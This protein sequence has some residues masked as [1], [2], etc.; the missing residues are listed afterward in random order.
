M[1]RGPSVTHAPKSLRHRYAREVMRLARVDDPRIEAVFAGTPREDFLPP[2]PWTILDAGMA[3][4]TSV[5]ADLYRDVLV[6]LDRRNGINNGE[7]ALHAAWL[8][9]VDP[10]PGDGVIHVGVGGGYYT[11]ML[12]QLVGPGGRVDAFEVH[13]GLAALAAR[14]LEPFGNVAVHAASAFGRPLPPADVVY[15][16]A[17][18]FAPDAEWLRALSPRG[19]LV[20]PWQPVAQWGPAV[21]VRRE[22][23]GFSARR[24]M[25]VGFVVCTGQPMGA[26]GEITAPGLAATRSVWLRDERAPDASATAVFRDVWFSAEEV[27]D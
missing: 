27:S 19:R 3:S 10:Q 2:P 7:P 11:A 15:V 5:V 22:P 20:F 12:A 17:G 23:G 4:R 24:L 1:P 16:N 18:V 13:E 14:N 25:D 21:L 26:A 9:A 8:A 6:V